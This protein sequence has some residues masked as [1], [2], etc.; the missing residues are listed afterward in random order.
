MDEINGGSLGSDTDG[1]DEF[2][3]GRATEFPKVK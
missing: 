1:S 2:E 3:L